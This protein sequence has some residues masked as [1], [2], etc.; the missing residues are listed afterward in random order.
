M[1]SKLSKSVRALEGIEL[2]NSIEENATRLQ[3]LTLLY[4]LFDKFGD[5]I[6][7]NRFKEVFSMTEIGKMIRDEGLKEGREEGLKEGMEVGKVEL[8]IKQLTKKFKKLPSKYEDKIK[9]LPI[10]TID[11]IAT[12][13]FDLE[14]VEDLEKY[15]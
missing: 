1:S 13:I 7:K 3:C 14:S 10:T 8:L 6:S 4:A 9:K 15:F 2:A 12:D 11:V 5:S